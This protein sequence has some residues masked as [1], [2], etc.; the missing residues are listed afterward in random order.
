MKQNKY[1]RVKR[2]V[3]NE[4]YILESCDGDIVT[5]Q[6]K[7]IDKLASVFT[8]KDAKDGDVLVDTLSGTRAVTILFRGINADGSINAYCGWNEYTFRVT[9]DGLGYGTLSSTQYVPATKEQR[10]LLFAKMK[11]AGYTWD[12]DKKELR[13]IIEPTFKVGDEIFRAARN[14]YFKIRGIEKDNGTVWYVTTRTRIADND[15]RVGEIVRINAFYQNEYS[16]A[17]KLHYDISSFYAGMPVLVRDDNAEEWKYTD[18]SHISS[19]CSSYKFVA[20]C[21]YWRQCIPFE[22]NKHLLGTTDMPSSEYINW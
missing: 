2:V 13:K 3:D 8:I 6:I 19:K 17:P 21:S 4:Y 14:E 16:I 5:Q 15:K 12:A 9:T 20:N 10:E 22:P 11:E 1:Y 18:F 7:D